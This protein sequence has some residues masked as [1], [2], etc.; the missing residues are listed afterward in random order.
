MQSLIH[1]LVK[2]GYVDSIE[3]QDGKQNIYYLTNQCNNI[4]A[5][6]E[7]TEEDKKSAEEFLK[8]VGV[9]DE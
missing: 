4:T 7:L 3:Y 8:R 6:F 2:K 1:R 5:P 9:T